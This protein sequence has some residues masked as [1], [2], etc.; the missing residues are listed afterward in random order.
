MSVW[1]ILKFWNKQMKYKDHEISQCEIISY[2]EAIVN[3]L[4]CFAIFSRMRLII[5]N[6]LK[7]VT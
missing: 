6:I 5:E 2:V 1:I 7:E 4:M 3:I